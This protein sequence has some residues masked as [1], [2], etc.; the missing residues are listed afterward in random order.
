MFTSHIWVDDLNV[1]QLFWKDRPSVHWDLD[2]KSGE[3]EKVLTWE[4]AQ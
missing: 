2:L 1:G 3:Q 4:V